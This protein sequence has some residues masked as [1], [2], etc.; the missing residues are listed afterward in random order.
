MNAPAGCK[1]TLALN[2]TIVNI[3]V[4]MIYDRSIQLYD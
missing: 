2:A 4:R 3:A 1:P